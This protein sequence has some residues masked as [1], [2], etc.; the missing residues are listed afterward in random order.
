MLLTIFKRPG[1]TE[2]EHYKRKCFNYEAPLT[3]QE[4]KS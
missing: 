3:K 2:R 1:G 4:S